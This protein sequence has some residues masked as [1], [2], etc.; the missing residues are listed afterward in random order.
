M[1]IYDSR[2][3]DTLPTIAAM[4]T[5]SM[6]QPTALQTDMLVGRKIPKGLRRPGLVLVSCEFV[7]RYMSRQINY[8]GV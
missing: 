4:T 8:S 3:R 2:L 1:T 6:Y 7:A 5:V